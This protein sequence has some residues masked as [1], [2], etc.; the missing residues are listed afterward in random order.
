MQEVV[1]E[2][3]VSAIEAAIANARSIGVKPEALAE[4]EAALDRLKEEQKAA[5]AVRALKFRAS[6]ASAPVQDSMA[7]CGRSSFSRT[8]AQLRCSARRAAMP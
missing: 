1:R 7:S 6:M 5:D 4:A 2:R 3:D 8:A